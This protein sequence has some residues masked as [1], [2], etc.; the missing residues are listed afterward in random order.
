MSKKLN[1]SPDNSSVSNKNPMFAGG[2]KD[3]KSYPSVDTDAVR[4]GTAKSPPTLSK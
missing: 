3:I 4:S 2:V 1:A